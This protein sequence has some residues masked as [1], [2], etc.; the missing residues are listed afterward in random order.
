MSNKTQLQTNNA[1]LD[2][3]IARINAAKEV[4]ASLP[5]AGGSGSGAN[6]E[7]CTVTVTG[8]QAG[9]GHHF[10][11]VLCMCYENGEYYDDGGMISPSRTLTFYNV[12]KFSLFV[13]CPDYP[14]TGITTDNMNTILE[15]ENVVVMQVFDY[16][17][18]ND[19]RCD[20]YL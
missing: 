17:S 20:I 16:G 1:S 6:V 12:P 5:E 3:Y 9:Q 15:N 7:T 4:A 18:T 14:I 19:C 13:I 10:A 2:G 11:E 8:I